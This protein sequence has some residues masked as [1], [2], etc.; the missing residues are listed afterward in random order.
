VVNQQTLA[1]SSP[2]SEGELV[3]G[4]FLFL[5]FGLALF[6]FFRDNFVGVRIRKNLHRTFIGNNS[7]DGK[8]IEND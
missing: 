3:T 2:I 4:F 6:A 1:T 7:P 5:I 8:E